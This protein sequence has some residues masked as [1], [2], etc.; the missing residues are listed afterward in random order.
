MSSLRRPGAAEV[1]R[2]LDGQ[3]RAGFSYPEVGATRTGP[4][5]GYRF[6]RSSARVGTGEPA[7]E[8]AAAGLR[9]YVERA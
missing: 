6:E 4:P 2:V 3:R 9:R 5:A 7:F 8:K 1:A